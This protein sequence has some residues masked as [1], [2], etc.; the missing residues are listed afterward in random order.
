MNKYN[1]F[2]LLF[3]SIS[4]N[5]KKD[6]EKSHC[7]HCKTTNDLKSEIKD[8]EASNRKYRD[9]IAKWMK[10][11]YDARDGSYAMCEK[12]MGE[13]VKYAEKACTISTRYCKA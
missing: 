6:H 7:S 8:L 5:C 4:I 1:L 3:F 2:L 9:E 13:A 12:W 10:M 11:Y